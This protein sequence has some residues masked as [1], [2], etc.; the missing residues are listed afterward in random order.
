MSAPAIPAEREPSRL[1]PARLAAAFTRVRAVSRALAAP[2]EPEDQ[3]IQSMPDV[4]PTKWHLAHTSWF[5]ETFVL[6]AP[7]FEPYRPSWDFLFNS[8]YQSVG[9]MHARPRRGLLSRPTVAEILAYREWIDER[10]LE[11][12]DRGPSERRRELIE[13]GLHHEQQH[14]ELIL[15]D[16][17]HV[18][19]QNPLRPRDRR[20]PI[21]AIH[22]AP[23]PPTVG[24]LRW[25][26]LP[27]GLVELGHPFDGAEFGYDNEGPRHKCW[28]EPY[29]VASRPA[30]C[31]EYLAFMAD[32]GYARPQLWLSEGWEVV[33]R[34][35]WRAPGYWL[36]AEGQPEPG[37]TALAD[38]QLFTLDGPRPIHG[39]E[40]VCHLSFYEAEAFARW[41]D[42]RLP[43]E[44]EW[45]HLVEGLARAGNLLPIDAAALGE[46]SLHPRPGVVQDPASGLQQIFGD[47]WEWTASPYV[48]YPG[49]APPPGAVGEYNGK[50]MCN[51]HVLRG[52]SCATARDHIRA[53]YR[54]FFPAPT[55]WQFSGVRLA[56]DL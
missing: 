51:Q 13:L 14:Q 18:L 28:L 20:A 53:S 40:P 2:L 55:R 49:Y 4:S 39:D 36:A 3:C 27:G 19:A 50:F 21:P 16:I 43:T 22:G 17:K 42:A 8:Y 29:A 56:K 37:A 6:D 23:S 7:G 12:L 31:S 54:N 15:T 47:V 26:E 48:P 38:W 1:D 34:E 9:R 5:F 46:A 35:G 52:G 32:G 25:V 44:A 33:Q 24:P 45:E 41:S 10:V 11:L 30:T